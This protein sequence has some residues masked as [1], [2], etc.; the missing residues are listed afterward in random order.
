MLTALQKSTSS[1]G[2][3]AAFLGYYLLFFKGNLYVSV[4]GPDEEKE[5]AA[6]IISIAKAVDNKIQKQSHY[7]H[8]VDQV[9]NLH[10]IPVDRIIYLRGNIALSNIYNFHHS[11][12]FDFPEAAI[13]FSVNSTIYLMKYTRHD[14]CSIKYSQAV[15]NLKTSR[16]FNSFAV[17]NSGISF[18]DNSNHVFQMDHINDF[19]II[20]QDDS[21]FGSINSFMDMLKIY[22]SE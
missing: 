12:I 17:Q 18:K 6:E 11:D 3:E 14:T 10:D 15:E 1:F 7:P 13:C 8:L 2:S 19:I 5:T 20:I 4:S 21:E 9:R 16:K 22:F